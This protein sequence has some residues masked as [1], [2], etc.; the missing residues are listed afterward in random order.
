MV[1]KYDKDN[2]IEYDMKEVKG[3]D[4]LIK[5]LFIFQMMMRYVYS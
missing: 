4:F 2:I 3:E 1:K 5:S